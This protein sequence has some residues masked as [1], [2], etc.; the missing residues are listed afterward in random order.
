MESDSIHFCHL[1]ELFHPE[2][3]DIFRKSLKIKGHQ[4]LP[5]KLTYP[6]RN[7]WIGTVFPIIFHGCPFLKETFLSQ[8]CSPLINFLRESSQGLRLFHIKLQGYPKRTQLNNPNKI[9][10]GSPTGEIRFK[11]AEELWHEDGTRIFRQS[12]PVIIYVVTNQR[13]CP[14]LSISG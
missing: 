10:P 12:S 9:M 7:Q 8:G 6:L 11:R 4:L 14:K 1:L 2:N 5:G 13:H 3:P